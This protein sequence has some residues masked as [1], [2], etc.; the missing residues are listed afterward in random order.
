MKRHSGYMAILFNS[1]DRMP[2]L[3]STLDSADSLFA[4]VKT[5]SFYLPYIEVPYQDTASGS[6]QPDTS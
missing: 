6:L 3:A 4:L 5:L 2:F 1:I